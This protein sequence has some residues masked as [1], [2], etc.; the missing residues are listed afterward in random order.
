M[1]RLL[2][3]FS[4]FVSLLFVGCD[5]L[6]NALGLLVFP[7][8]LYYKSF[9]LEYVDVDYGK[10]AVVNVKNDCSVTVLIPTTLYARQNVKGKKDAEALA[11]HEKHQELS[12]KNGDVY[13]NTKLRSF[14]GEAG[15]GWLPEAT[16]W[17]TDYS[18]SD[19]TVFSNEDFDDLHPSGTPLDDIIKVGY[20]TYRFFIENGYRHTDPERMNTSNDY[21]G[22]YVQ[23]LLLEWESEDSMFMQATKHTAFG[24]GLDFSFISKPTI[25]QRHHLTCVVMV[26]GKKSYTFEF[27]ID[28][29]E[30]NS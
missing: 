16:V 11:L 17:N 27:D 28:F 2:C 26:E 14:D 19:I 4:L 21:A 10:K 24:G 23:K 29:G 22:D 3:I 8:D 5:A 13:Y 7:L 1:K 12:V 25:E 20:H 18:I 30:P 15:P 9:V 6:G